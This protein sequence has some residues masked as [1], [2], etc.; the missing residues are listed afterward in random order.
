MLAQSAHFGAVGYPYPPPFHS[1]VV[2]GEQNQPMAM[3]LAVWP[4]PRPGLLV[5]HGLFN[6]GG[7]DY[8]RRIAVSAYRNWRFNVGVLDLRG[9]GRTSRLSKA[10]TSA[11]WKE[12]SD[13][14]AAAS[15]LKDSG[16]TSVGVYAVSFGASAALRA[17]HD[18]GATAMLQGGVLSI[19]SPADTELAAK[20]LSNADRPLIGPILRSLVARAIRARTTQDTW[21][22][23]VRTLEDAVIQVSAP[24]YGVSGDDIWKLSSAANYIAACKVPTLIIHARDDIVISVEHAEMLRDRA[25]RNPNVEVLLTDHGDHGAFDKAY[26]GWHNDVERRFFMTHAH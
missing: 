3:R 23:S 20:Q 14:F 2:L 24:Y 4:E 8:V 26:P 1:T 9:F 11:G 12:S 10:P 13:L 18:S 17:S 21:G 5:V 7:F 25:A 19:S 22:E 15:R 16:S 6:H